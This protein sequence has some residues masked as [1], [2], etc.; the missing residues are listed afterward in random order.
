MTYGIDLTTFNMVA[1]GKA[2]A[3]GGTP[4]VLFLYYMDETRCRVPWHFHIDGDTLPPAEWSDL[5]I[6]DQTHMIYGVVGGT[7]VMI[8]TYWPDKP[9]VL[10]L[11]SSSQGARRILAP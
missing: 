4:P 6:R 2:E 11:F 10:N 9:I 8:D 7:L 5:V 3:K 1:G